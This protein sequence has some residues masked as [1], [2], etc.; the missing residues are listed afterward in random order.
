MD[1][2]DKFREDTRAAADDF[3]PEMREPCATDRRL[4]G[5]AKLT[6][7]T[8]RRSSGWSGWRRAVEGDDCAEY[9]GGGLSP[10]ETKV[11]TQEW[12]GRA[13]NP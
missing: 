3:P 8:M 13:R 4:L 1:D 11:L 6:S 5:A 10:S 7:R 12:R 2:L 9:G